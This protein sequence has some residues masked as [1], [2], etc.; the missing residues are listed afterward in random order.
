MLFRSGSLGGA[1]VGVYMVHSSVNMLYRVYC[2]M[3]H[4]DRALVVLL[5]HHGSVSCGDGVCECVGGV[6]IG[7]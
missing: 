7:L 1:C 4:L 6:E 5:A 2:G 3:V